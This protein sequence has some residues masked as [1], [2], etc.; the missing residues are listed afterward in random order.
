M[1]LRISLLASLSAFTGYILHS[2][3]FN[4]NALLV[5]AGVFFLAAGAGAMNHYQDRFLDCLFCRT[6]GRPLPRKRIVP[7]WVLLFAWTMIVTGTAILLRGPFPGRAAL[8]GLMAVFLYNGLYT[9]LKKKTS[10]ALIPG[11]LCGLMP[12]LIGWV[13]ADGDMAAPQI[14]IL[15]V[16]WGLWQLP[17]FWLLILGNQ[18]EYRESDIPNMLHL[19]TGSQLKKIILVWIFGFI[20]TAF[21]LPMVNVLITPWLHWLLATGLLAMLSGVGYFLFIKSDFHNYPRLFHYLNYTMA[22]IITL[23]LVDRYTIFFF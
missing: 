12:P 19:F 10:L 9:P 1:K 8:L 13:A 7:S 11:V 16:M 6:K 20:C 4:S 17:H 5:S 14:M 22:F 21:Q 2:E 23:I 18:Q 3:N 15:M